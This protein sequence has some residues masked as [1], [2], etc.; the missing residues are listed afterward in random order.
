MAKK[1]PRQASRR[2][3]TAAK[4]ETRASWKGNLS[5]GLVSFPVEAFNALNRQESDIH[6]HQLHAKCHSRIHYEKVCPIHGTVSNQEIVSGYEYEKGKYIEVDPEELQY[7]KADNPHG[8]SID[9]FIGKDTVDPLYFDGRMYYL[10]P[11]DNG[12][13][14][15]Y[16]ILRTAMENEERYAIGQIVLSGKEQLA[17]IRPVG[18]LLQMAMLNFDAEIRSPESFHRQIKKPT[19]TSRQLNL[20]QTLVREWSDDQFNFADYKDDYRQRVKKLIAEK[21]KGHKVTPPKVEDEEPVTINLMD[22]LKKSLAKSKSRRTNPKQ[23]S[24]SA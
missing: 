3:A 16:G 18:P 20:A 22:A 17:L 5:F 1:K 14:E 12:A 7:L 24:H 15:A 9:S 10:I 8:I 19:S 21:S 13:H 11:A 23:R 6:F 2:T 4:P